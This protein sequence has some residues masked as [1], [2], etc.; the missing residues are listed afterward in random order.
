MSEVRGHRKTRVGVVVSDKMNCTAVVEI[1][2]RVLHPKYK[3]Y[4]KRSKR[5]HVHDAENT[6]RVGDR[7]MIEETRPL[8]KL[9]RWRLKEVIEKAP[10]FD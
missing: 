1:T 8:S 5:Y 10:V 3:K 6:C 2:R 9:K 4:V 7:V